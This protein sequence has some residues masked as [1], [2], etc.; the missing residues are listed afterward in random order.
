MKKI[1]WASADTGSGK[2]WNGYKCHNSQNKEIN[3]RPNSGRFVLFTQQ[4]ARF[5]SDICKSDQA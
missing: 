3:K 1:D 4:F 2:R 5:L